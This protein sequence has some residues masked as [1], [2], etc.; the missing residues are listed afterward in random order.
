[1]QGAF[2]VAETLIHGQE[3]QR[4]TDM[5]EAGIID[6]RRRQSAPAAPR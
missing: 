1:M 6:V 4:R 5:V 2:G 3:H